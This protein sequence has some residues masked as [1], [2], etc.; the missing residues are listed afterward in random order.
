MDTRLKSA[1]ILGATGLTGS[2]LLQFLLKDSRYGKI[3]LFSR[4][5]VGIK[6]LKI[7][8]FLG[9]L[10][11]LKAFKND[12]M[13]DEVF[14]CIGTT[15]AKTPDKEMY[16]M[17]DYGI[18]KKAAELCKKNGIDILVIIS[19]LGANSKSRI[20]YNRVKGQME[21][22]VLRLQIPKTHILQPSLIGGTR[23]EKRSGEWWAKQYMKIINFS[24]IGPLRKY[25][26]ISPESI[27]KSML[28]L[29]N[30]KHNA[31]RIPS[32]E[33]KQLAKQD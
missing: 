22:A 9:D 29:A 15:K 24:L 23:K 19:A 11:N 14:C 6:H 30:N 7:E 5:S 1:I 20:F 12:F 13:A 25:R 4:T 2:L 10:I 31:L 3:K 28:W 18:P 17:I 33:I 8:E 27:V 16:G 26:S 32:D 21:E